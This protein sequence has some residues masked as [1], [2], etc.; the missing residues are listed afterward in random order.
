MASIVITAIGDD[1]AGLVG[2][3]SEVVAR[4]GGNWD[5]S[6]M[7]EL[8]G[9]FA[10]VILVTLADASVDQ[11][12]VD[13]DELEAEGLLDITAERASGAPDDPGMQSLALELVGQ[14]HPGIVH[15]I[16]QVLAAHHVSIDELETEIVPAP[17]G[18]SLFQ[19]R[20][21]LHLP[22]TLAIDD[23]RASL[24]DVAADLMVDLDLS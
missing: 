16:S 4:H 7:T 17:Q 12:I 13:L 24:E 18:G 5:Q 11:F 20:A 6:H 10:G 14:D 3:L 2:A 23:L 22:D 21:V 1:R 15:D 9:K 8:A 19:A